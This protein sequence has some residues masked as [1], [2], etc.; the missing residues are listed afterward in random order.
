M[1]ITENIVVYTCGNHILC[2]AF[3]H[4]DSEE[5]AVDENTEKMVVL[6]ESIDDTQHEAS[7]KALNFLYDWLEEAGAL[8]GSI[9]VADYDTPVFQLNY[10]T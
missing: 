7:M 8:V 10:T 5:T 6:T 3:N 2:W 1:P 4:R 9:C